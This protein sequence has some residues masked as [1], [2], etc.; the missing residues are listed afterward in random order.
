MQNKAVGVGTNL[1]KAS[2]CIAPIRTKAY[3]YIGDSLGILLI[4]SINSLFINF[5]PLLI[6]NIISASCV[7]VFANCSLVTTSCLLV[8]LS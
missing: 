2:K 6:F 7:L 1:T 8:P 3:N 5:I 4:L